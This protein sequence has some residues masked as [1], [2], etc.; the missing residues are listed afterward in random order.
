M[1]PKSSMQ[2]AAVKPSIG[3]PAGVWSSTVMPP[4]AEVEKLSLSSLPVKVIGLVV[5]SPPLSG[6]LR[7]TKPSIRMV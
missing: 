4:A 2:S 5:I 1:S 6:A 7:E 3:L